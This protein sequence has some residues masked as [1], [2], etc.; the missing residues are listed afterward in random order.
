[1]AKCPACGHDVRT[2]FFCDLDGWSHL[3]CAHC[4]ARLEVKPRLVAVWFFPVLLSL[5]GLARLGHTFAV[6]AEVLMVSAGVAGAL[7]LVVR[8]QVRLRKTAQP[9]PNIRLN[10]DGPSN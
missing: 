9:K 6:V 4:K 7:L 2:P 3:A 1:M 5:M 8:P 10:I